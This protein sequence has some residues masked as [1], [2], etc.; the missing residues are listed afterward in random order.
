MNEVNVII[1]VY[2]GLNETIECIKSAYD[3]MPKYAKMIV[4]NDCSPDNDLNLWLEQNKDKYGYDLHRNIENLGF[5]KTVNFAM[6][7]DSS[8]DIL[9]LNSDVEVSNDWLERIVEV[10][11]LSEDI[12]SVTPFSNNATICSYP[13]FCQDNE[14]AMKKKLT[15]IDSACALAN[16]AKDYVEVPTGVGFCMYI[17]RS[18]LNH[19][20]LFDSQT[21]GKGYGEENDW[22]QRAIKLGWRNVH[23]TNVFV[24]HKGGVSFASEQHPRQKVALELLV[25]KHPNY[26]ADVMEFV[27]R[28]PAKLSRVKLAVELVRTSR[29]SILQ[30]EHALGGGVCRH[31]SELIKNIEPD[32]VSVRL[33]QK[34]NIISLTL[35]ESNYL[36]FDVNEDFDSLIHILK[37]LNFGLIHFHHIHGLDQRLLQLA[38]LLSIDYV[39]T[40]HDFYLLNGNPALSDSDGVF[41]G[42]N[43][44]ETVLELSKSNQLAG[45]K[46]NGDDGRKKIIEFIY[47]AKKII[48]PSHD[49]KER[50]SKFYRIDDV[51]K[52]VYHIDKYECANMEFQVPLE[53]SRVR[54]LVIGAISFEKG[55]KILN[56][57]AH[58][59]SNLVEIHLLGTSCIPLHSSINDHGAYLDSELVCKMVAIRPTIVWYTSQCAETYCYTLTPSIALQ[60][61]IIAPKIGAFIERLSGYKKS[62]ILDDYS[63]VDEVYKA[64]L[65]M[66][67]RI[68]NISAYEV[69]LNSDVGGFFY[70]G[71]YK[72]LVSERKH[73]LACVNLDEMVK[74]LPR[75]S[76]VVT[77]EQMLYSF[78][79]RLYKGRIG[80]FLSF[81]IPQKYFRILKRKFFG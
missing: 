45:Y 41:F 34:N 81:F 27:S 66:S 20:G 70:G 51:S 31:V 69:S 79:L 5:V 56:E 19:V 63:N 54:V 13:N 18:C 62:I 58:R 44:V 74:L 75:S 35:H 6:S 2:R 46:Y 67:E 23:A 22:C 61:P 64:V 21:F 43:D 29:K 48:F 40:I 42:D 53:L 39:I 16:D 24:Y 72:S 7:L 4:V 80:R 10:A 55:A 12:G 49:T 3:T 15:E 47:G 60:L 71:E 65:L 78:M 37:Y 1:P 59:F 50:F 17:K 33:N 9:L 52:V 30:V 73:Q 14:L 68:S 57:F 36:E 26:I 28:D 8:K 76:E 11:Y 32:I 25:K 38:S 77:R